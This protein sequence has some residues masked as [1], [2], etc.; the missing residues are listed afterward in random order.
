MMGTEHDPRWDAL[1]D[2]GLGN[3][4]ADVGGHTDEIRRVDAQRRGIL[5]M[6]P[7]RVAVGDLVQPLGIAAAGMDQ[8][9]QAERGDEDELPLLSVD[10]GPMYVAANVIG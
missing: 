1:C 3:E 9:R 7:D 2:P 4:V 10:R 6:D 8:R 5:R